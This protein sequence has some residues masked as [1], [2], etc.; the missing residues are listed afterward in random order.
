[1]AGIRL[2]V[3]QLSEAWLNWCCRCAPCCI[4]GNCTWVSFRRRRHT[5][6]EAADRSCFRRLRWSNIWG[7]GS[8]MRNM[9]IIYNVK[10][11]ICLVFASA[12]L[13]CH[14]TSGRHVCMLPLLSRAWTACV[15]A[16]G[17]GFELRKQSANVNRT[18]FDY[19]LITKVN[20][21]PL[22]VIKKIWK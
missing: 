9:P 22:T 12:T 17:G 8:T 5:Y 2:R 10:I 18:K 1:M 6:S 4:M 16:G 15:R 20:T 21:V 3:D 14:F 7:P 13:D 19:W 11:A